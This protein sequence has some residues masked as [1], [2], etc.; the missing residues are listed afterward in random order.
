M[1][2][3]IFEMIN[4]TKTK[5]GSWPG[6]AHALVLSKMLRVRIAIV[7]VQNNYNGLKDWF[8]SDNW[9]FEEDHPGLTETMLRKEP[10]RQKTCFL[11]QTNSM[12][13]TLCVIGRIILITL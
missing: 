9:I 3:F 1:N 12:I 2:N 5:D 8:D 4:T 7:I 13:L 10:N 11:L 6:E